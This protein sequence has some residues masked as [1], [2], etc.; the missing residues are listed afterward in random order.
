MGRT[1][2]YQYRIPGDD[3]DTH[4]C[5][6]SYEILPYYIAKDH[7]GKYTIQELGD[8][9]KGFIS[10]L[11][12]KPTQDC[13]EAILIFAFLLNEMTAINCSEVEICFE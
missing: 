10:E 3:E 4:E 8:T 7:T 9:I 2:F 13:S 12:Q 5:F 6:S 1:A 11:S